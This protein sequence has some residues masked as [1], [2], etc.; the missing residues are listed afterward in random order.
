EATVADTVVL[1]AHGL[2]DGEEIG[3]LRGVVRVASRAFDVG[4]RNGRHEHV[5]GLQSLEGGF[6]GVDVRLQRRLPLVGDR[7]GTHTTEGGCYTPGAPRGRPPIV[8]RER[9]GLPRPCPWPRWR[10]G[11]ARLEAGEPLTD[12]GEKA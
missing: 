9:Q 6:E 4:G 8:L 11:L 1:R 12:I 3:F 10:R 2:S 7:P 5:L